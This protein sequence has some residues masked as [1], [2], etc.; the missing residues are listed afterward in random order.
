MADSGWFKG[1][2]RALPALALSAL[3]CLAL[4]APA[5]A[6]EFDGR[7][8]RAIEIE[9]L[10]LLGP[11]AILYYLGLAQGETLD[12]GLLDA[13]IREL[14]AKSLI[15]DLEVAALPEGDGV[16]LHLR[17]KERA[18]LRSVEYVGLKRLSKTDIEDRIGREHIDI[19]EGRP[20]DRGAMAQ[21]KHLL[22]GMYGEKGYRFAAIN[23]EYEPLGKGEVRAKVTVDEGDRVRIGDIDFEG[24]EVFG[25]LRLRWV[26]KKTKESG[27][28]NRILKKDIYN[29]ANLEED[30]GKVRDLYRGAG[31]KN[32]LVGEPRIDVRTEGEKRRLVLVVPIDEGERW[33]LGQITV[34]GSEKITEK[35]IRSLITLPEGSWLRS[36]Q[37]KSALEKVKQVYDNTGY[38][39]AKIDQELVER[40]GYV[41][42]LVIKITENDQFQ[43]GRIE[44]EGNTSTRDKVLRRELRVQEGLNVNLAGVKNSVYKI[45]Q[46]GYFKLD[47]GEPVKFDANNEKKEVNLT[48]TGKEDNRTE[49]QFGAGFSET[50]G[51]F[52]QISFRTLNF[53]GRGETLGLSAETG[54]QRKIFDISYFVPWFLDKPQ[55]AGVQLFRQDFDFVSRDIRNSDQSQGAVLTYGRSFGLFQ[56]VNISYTR[57]KLDRVFENRLD[58]RQSF[59]QSLENSQ[60]NPNWTYNSVDNRFEPTR[61]QR[62]RGSLIYSGGVLGGNNYYVRP[63]LTYTLFVPV[64]KYPLRTVF[65]LNVETGIVEPFG[66]FRTSQGVRRDRVLSPLERFSLGGENSVRG[67]R[68]R[69]IT[70]RDDQDRLVADPD[71]AFLDLGGD[72]YFQVNVEYHLLVGGPFRFIVF[73][74]GGN[75]WSDFTTAA[76]QRIKQSF[77]LQN[78]RW[79]AGAELRV[80]IPVFGAPLRF[81]YS[82]NLTPLPGD[83]FDTFRF[84]VGAVF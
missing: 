35:T 56:G 25:D 57:S 45:N 5:A 19:G 68:Y 74:D 51:F 41:A 50:Q 42:D 15:D 60:L 28:I 82:N 67:H 77:D 7:T 18:V 9:G 27:P 71:I 53:L 65:G 22:E 70:V 80:L 72:E 1:L 21:V 34:S 11:E 31:Y 16:K 76:G 44:F 4:R 59:A 3:L 23:I 20:L 40:E 63:E 6:S 75:V 73:A 32:V 33:R 26:M 39:F 8:I 49:L 13:K 12:E 69:T 62:L 29:P 36:D 30:L 17:I 10:E 2:C 52:G 24:N 14:W 43:V 81:I 37:I 47:E 66:T 38:I 58:N 54:T 61:G 79:T 83:E 78:L 84:S 55:S 46:L 48:F 64:T